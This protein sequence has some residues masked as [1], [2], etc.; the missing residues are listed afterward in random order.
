MN[1]LKL[2]Q[3]FKIILRSSF[4][5]LLSLGLACNKSSIFIRKVFLILFW[6]R[7]ERKKSVTDILRL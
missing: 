7:D 3:S 2:F 6:V 1:S 5:D 4:K